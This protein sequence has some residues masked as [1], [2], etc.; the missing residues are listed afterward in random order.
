MV[1]SNICLQ[2]HAILSMQSTLIHI[3][4]CIF[5]FNSV[6]DIQNLWISY[7]IYTACTYS[8]I[9]KDARYLI[10]FQISNSKKQVAKTLCMDKFGSCRLG[11]KYSCKISFL[12]SSQTIY[13][14]LDFIRNMTAHA[15]AYISL[16]KSYPLYRLHVW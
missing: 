8:N 7:E 11:C 12:T 6:Y 16:T 4:L 1:A 14:G 3:M 13:E 10:S 5:N 2:N 15:Y 9:C